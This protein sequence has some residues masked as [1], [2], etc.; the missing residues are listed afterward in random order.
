MTSLSIA[1]YLTRLTIKQNRCQL[2]DTRAPGA[3]K[4]LEKNEKY[5]CGKTTNRA[6]SISAAIQLVN[7][8]IISRV[9]FC[10]SLL[11]GAPTNLTGSSQSVFNVAARHVYGSERFDHVNDVME[12]GFTGC[13]SFSE[14]GSSSSPSFLLALHNMDWLQTT[15][16]NL[17]CNHRLV[18]LLC[19]SFGNARQTC[20]SEDDYPVCWKIIWCCWTACV[21]LT[22]GHSQWR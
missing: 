11:Y 6:L 17:A 10:N 22:T 16:P 13:V 19:S 20:C 8:F 4:A 9:D 18:S 1:D 2:I 7:S 5:S 14:S 12:T 3:N 21:E 15:S